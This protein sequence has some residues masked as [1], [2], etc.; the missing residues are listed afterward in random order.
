MLIVSGVSAAKINGRLWQKAEQTI[1][2]LTIISLPIVNQFFGETV[3]CTGLLTGV[4][5]VAAVQQYIENNGLVDEMILPSNTMKE[6]DIVFFSSAYRP[7][8]S[9]ALASFAS[10]S[11]RS[12]SFA[13]ASLAAR[14]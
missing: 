9:A 10:V 4:D 6:F 11:S 12:F 2:N 14:S 5:I 8:I 13:S 7:T 1:D 3:T